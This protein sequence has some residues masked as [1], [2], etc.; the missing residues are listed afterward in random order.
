[1]I[2][3]DSS[4]V[5]GYCLPPKFYTLEFDEK[6][7]SFWSIREEKLANYEHVFSSWKR[8]CSS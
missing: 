8:E 3:C 4:A 7:Y 2:A 1:M 5:A 6:Y